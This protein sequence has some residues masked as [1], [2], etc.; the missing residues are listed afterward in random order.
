MAAADRARAARGGARSSP[1]PGH[2]RLRRPGRV[3]GRH[4]RHLV[5]RCVQPARDH[6]RAGHPVRPAGVRAVV[7][8]VLHPLH[9]RVH[10]DRHRLPPHRR[11]RVGD[12]RPDHG[13]LDPRVQHR[14]RATSSRRS[15]TA[16]RSTSIRPSCSS[17]SRPAS[18][19][20][21]ILG[22]FMVVPVLGIISATWRTVLAAMG[23]RAMPP[24]RPDPDDG[25][26]A[27]AVAA[28]AASPP[29]TRARRRG[30]PTARA[31]PRAGL[32]PAAGRSSVARTTG[33]KEHGPTDVDLPTV[34]SSL[35]CEGRSGRPVTPRGVPVRYLLLIYEEPPTRR[36]A[37]R[38]WAR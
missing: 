12:R 3:H 19:I 37:T 20:A 38:D 28:V 16:G 21:G 26:A 1:R 33:T 35:G 7:L 15:C 29:A 23:S 8:P 36:R 32:S 14:D 17:A 24:P 9:R 27:D 10:L 4:G 6:G 13:D 5:R 34:R 30:R 25:D 22:M 31:R 18:A 11:A 2:G